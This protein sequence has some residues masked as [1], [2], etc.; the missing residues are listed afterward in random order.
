LVTIPIVYEDNHLLVVEKPPNILCQGDKTGD[1]DMLTLLK[2]DLKTRYNKPG[3]VYLG[4]VQRLDRPVG[5]VMVFA[6]TSKA[7]ARLSEQIRN[8]T[9]LK[10][11]IALVHGRPAEEKGTLVHY[12]VKDNRTNK[13]SVVDKEVPKAKEAILDYTVVTTQQGLSLVKINL[14]T[15][16]P[17]QIRVQ[18][19]TLGHPLLGDY[20]YGPKTKQTS[21]KQA[22]KLEPFGLWSFKISCL[23]P[24]TK[25]RLHFN[26]LPVNYE[27]WK[28]FMPELLK[29][30]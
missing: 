4:L 11:Y 21:R 17:H 19:A 20:R 7:A 6:R 3:N 14:H 10:T 25:E 23:H 12:L 16:R 2:Q 26:S 5:G 13:V 1:P 28:P 18:F 27:L 30:T 8:K 9:F 29:L 22:D 24:I 15:G